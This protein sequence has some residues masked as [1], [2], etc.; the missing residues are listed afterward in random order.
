M[1]DS[2]GHYPFVGD[3]P[4][5]VHKAMDEL[6]DLGVKL[7]GLAGDVHRDTASIQEAWPK[8]HTGQLAKQDA[9]RMGKSLNEC[10][11]A[12]KGAAGALDGLVQPLVDGRT[13]VHTLNDSYRTLSAALS[14]PADHPFE[15]YLYAGNGGGGG[16]EGVMLPEE[17]WRHNRAQKA[18][19]DLA[20]AQNE[21]GY[22]TLTE[23]DQAYQKAVVKPVTEHSDHCNKTLK[24]LTDGGRA[25][26]NHGHAVGETMYD[27]SFSLLSALAAPQVADILSGHTPFPTEP[28]AVHDAWMELSADQQM[29]LLNND[30]ARFGNLNGIP[31]KDRDTANNFVLKNQVDQ[32]QAA[33]KA[34]GLPT[35]IDPKV[36][37]K[38]D[39]EGQSGLIQGRKNLVRDAIT[40]AGISFDQ[41]KHA[42]RVNQQ[43]NPDGK[44]V[45]PSLVH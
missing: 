41:A 11:Q 27:V 25:P 18:K 35:T 5:R 26:A 8:G 44:S 21:A 6:F 22:Y 32:I 29:H 19:D 31:A 30:P 36:L 17:T 10:S 43:L 14:A 39:A 16:G 28:K 2:G 4:K 13:E 15:D 33:L 42:L 3:D 40:N 12:F 34:A 9:A 1:N 38:W 23:I 37:E 45:N 20:K 7:L 24:Q